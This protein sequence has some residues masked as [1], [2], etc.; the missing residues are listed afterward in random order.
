MNNIQKYFIV[1]ND[2]NVIYERDAAIKDELSKEQL[3]FADQVYAFGLSQSNEYEKITIKETR[4]SIAVAQKK[5]VTF[6]LY[7]NWCGPNYGSGTPINLPNKG[8]KNHDIC[9]GNK[10]RHKC[11]YDKTFLSYIN[12]N[13]KKMTGW[14]DLAIY[15]PHVAVIFI[16]VVI[17]RRQYKEKSKK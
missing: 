4:K 7:G 16:G 11:F 1:E 12:K 2:G 8:C 15:L 17:V 9:Y 5:A 13:Y 3:N 6:P 14:S 10:G